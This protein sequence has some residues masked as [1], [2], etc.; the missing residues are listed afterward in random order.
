MKADQEQTIE[1][2]TKQNNPL[3]G[4][5]D[6]P[7]LTPQFHA[8]SRAAPTPGFRSL[9]GLTVALMLPTVAWANQPPLANAGPDK[10]VYVGECIYLDGSAYDPDGDDSEEWYWEVLVRPNGSWAQPIPFYSDRPLFCPDIAG[11][12]L[13]SLIVGDGYSYSAPDTVKVTADVNLPPIAVATAT[14]TSGSAP[15]TVQF[16][17]SQSSDPEGRNRK[18][19]LTPLNLFNGVEVQLIVGAD[20]AVQI[21]DMFDA[22][23]PKLAYP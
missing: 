16:D 23:G 8:T 4:A 6:T 18:V 1:D 13:I 9:L 2:M 3:E 21:I 11:E 10:N 19:D 20:S 5:H 12:Y 7:D 15:L 22:P 14:P 17:G